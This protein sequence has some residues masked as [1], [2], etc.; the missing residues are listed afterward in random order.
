[1]KEYR[2]TIVEKLDVRMSVAIQA[3]KNMSDSEVIQL[4]AMIDENQ[5]TEAKAL[6]ESKSAIAMKNK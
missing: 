2:F 1:M 3:L 4:T 5:L 6:V